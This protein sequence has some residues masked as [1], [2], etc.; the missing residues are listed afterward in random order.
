MVKGNS[1]LKTF[2]V[3]I[4]NEDLFESIIESDGLAIFENDDPVV[5]RIC[6]KKTE[7]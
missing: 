2:I 5:I 6:A 1:F 7:N 3:Q 4:I